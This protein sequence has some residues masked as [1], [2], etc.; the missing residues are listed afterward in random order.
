[1]FLFGL[2]T[3]NQLSKSPDVYSF[4]ISEFKDPLVGFNSLIFKVVNSHVIKRVEGNKMMTKS[5]T[6]K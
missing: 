1:M 4:F 2:L 3:I 6:Y 5:K